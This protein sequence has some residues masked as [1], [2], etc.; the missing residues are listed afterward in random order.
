MTTEILIPT[1]ARAKLGLDLDDNLVCTEVPALTQSHKLLGEILEQKG[2]D[3]LM[4]LDLFLDVYTGHTF[5]LI[6]QM[7]FAARGRTLEEAELND[8]ARVEKERVMDRFR[9][10]DLRVTPGTDEALDWAQSSFNPYAIVTSTAPDRAVLTLQAAEIDTYFKGKKLFSCQ[11]PDFKGEPKSSP[12]IY[13]L[14]FAEMSGP[15]DEGLLKIGVEDSTK[16]GKSVVD[17]DSILIGNVG[18]LPIDKQEQRK[19]DLLSIGAK[20]VINHLGALPEV[21]N[22]LAARKEME[23]AELDLKLARIAGANIWVNETRN[24]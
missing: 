22:L 4:P 3:G 5:K 6:L 15:Q 10:G 2:L 13:D 20:V 11:D 16:G 24:D 9:Q 17:S 7:E 18:A 19:N 8:W 23:Q 12:D 21:V 14:A 1:G